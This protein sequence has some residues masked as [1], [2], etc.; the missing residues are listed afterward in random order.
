MD[1]M[2]RAL[3]L[4]LAFILGISCIVSAQD[5]L[6]SKKAVEKPTI[7]IPDLKVESIFNSWGYFSSD[8]TTINTE[9]VL[10]DPNF[11]LIPLNV[12]CDIY[13]NDIKMVRGLGENL[14]ITKK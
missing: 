10:D 1:I 5:G 12:Y 9:I 13:L 2:K 14:E 6:S 3:L 11:Y 8:T 4:V 7:A